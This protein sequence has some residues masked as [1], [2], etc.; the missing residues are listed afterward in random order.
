MTFI[1]RKSEAWLLFVA[2]C[3]VLF[4]LLAAGFPLLHEKDPPR[5]GFMAR[6]LVNRLALTD[7]C[8]FNE[9]RYTRHLSQ[10]DLHA[11]FQDHPLAFPH[12]PSGSHVRPPAHLKTVLRHE[13]DS[14]PEILP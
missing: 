8:L 2:G 11:P 1:F 12:F 6:Q 7:L 9:A 14:T 10:A 4:T 5:Q 13:L 3:I